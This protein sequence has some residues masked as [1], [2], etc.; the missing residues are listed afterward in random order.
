MSKPLLQN[1]ILVLM[2][3]LITSITVLTNNI[4]K[5]Q[6][7]N[8]VLVTQI[9]DLQDTTVGCYGVDNNEDIGNL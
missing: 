6:N 5:L 2:V 1:I 7:K 4:D 3:I 8:K 9:K